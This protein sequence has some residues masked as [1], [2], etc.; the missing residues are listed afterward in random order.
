M[1]KSGGKDKE[2]SVG[3]MKLEMPTRHPNG[4]VK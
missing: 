3:N 1:S 4:D 2:F